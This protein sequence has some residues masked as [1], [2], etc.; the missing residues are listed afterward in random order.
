MSTKRASER[1]ASAGFYVSIGDR[2]P[3]SEREGT[4]AST[5]PG[6]SESAARGSTVFIYPSSG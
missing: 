6:P 2:Q 4:V 5:S 3:S 1:L